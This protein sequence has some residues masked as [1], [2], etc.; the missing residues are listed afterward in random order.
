VARDYFHDLGTRWPSRCDCDDVSL[1]EQGVV[2]QELDDAVIS[3]VEQAVDFLAIG[4]S[5]GLSSNPQWQGKMFVVVKGFAKS[6]FV[7]TGLEQQSTD[8]IQAGRQSQRIEF[9][10]LNRSEF[11]ED[12]W[13][14]SEFGH[15]ASRR[16]L[17]RFGCVHDAVQNSEEKSV[18]H[19]AQSISDHARAHRT[20]ADGF[21]ELKQCLA[22]MFSQPVRSF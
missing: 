19:L 16:G 21:N 3:I 12:R 7:E 13:G 22:S 18:I 14:Q 11:I 10:H 4:A 15:H 8:A 2:E 5:S 1:S 9:L 17:S 20:L 6:L